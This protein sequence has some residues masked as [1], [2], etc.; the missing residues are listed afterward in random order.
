MRG[1]SKYHYVDLSLVDDQS[2]QASAQYSQLMR[3]GSAAPERSGFVRYVIMTGGAAPCVFPTVLNVADHIF[4]S[5]SLTRSCK[6]RQRS[7]RPADTAA[8]PSPDLAPE[9]LIPDAT[10][11][12]DELQGS[13]FLDNS[14][15]QEEATV[16]APDMF[17]RSVKFP[18]GEQSALLE[19]DPLELPSIHRYV[20]T[21]TDPDAVEALTAL[22]RSHC[23]SVIDSFRFCKEKMLWHHFSSFHGTLTV[24]VQKLFAHPDIAPWIKAC[25]FLMYQKMISFVSPLALQVVPLIVLKT[26]KAI[27]TK[28]TR[29]IISVFQTHP[30]HVRKARLLPAT[31]FANLLD[32]L[33][34]VN[35]AAHAAA[36]MLTNDANRE[37]MWQ[38]WVHH[39]RAKHVAQ[40]T[41]TLR[42][43]EMLKI[44]DII[45]HDI[46]ELLTPLT[47]YHHP[48]ALQLYVNAPRYY[49]QDTSPYAAPPLEDPSEGIL[50]RW[51]NFLHSLPSRFPK[52]DGKMIIHYMALASNAAIRDITVAQALSFGSWWITKVWVDEMLLWLVENG[53]FMD[54]DPANPGKNSRSTLP[55]G[56]TIA[57]D[58]VSDFLGDDSRPQ[59]AMSGSM[60]NRHSRVGSMDVGN[61]M[62][63]QRHQA[64]VNSV[65]PTLQAVQRPDLP[66]SNSSHVHGLPTQISPAGL[67]LPTSIQNGE[68]FRSVS[69][70]LLPEGRMNAIKSQLDG[71]DVN[72]DSGIALDDET[73]LS[74][75]DGFV[76]DNVGNSDPVNVVVC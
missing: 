36:N 53:G 65:P 32:R 22:Y 38:D 27:S 15:H 44:V 1:E 2:S 49:P 66:R 40:D 48:S 70:Q 39:V 67:V 74:K 63:H 54:Y 4:V 30:L 19:I 25:D 56:F 61:I 14:G 20:P 16:G 3:E 6:N 10:P 17:R 37:Q 29:H 18:A 59:T 8:F 51:A 42:T 13:L 7:L 43:A 23:I 34:R 58:A 35:E 69:T 76:A 71:Q 45:I 64:R 60:A 46:R 12:T 55:A 57:E 24:P 33:A 73:N 9:P 31:L 52:A 26:F 41:L 47:T 21:G 5:I 50:D 68:S 28:L 75:F 11:G 72:E 62:H